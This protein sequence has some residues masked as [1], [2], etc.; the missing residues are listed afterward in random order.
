MTIVLDGSGLTLEKLVRIARHG[1][2]VELAPEALERIKVCRAM[3][4]DKLKAHEVMYGTNTGI[5]EFSEIILSDE[6]VLQFQRYLI[7]NHAA[8]IGDPAPIEHVRA[9]MAG[10]IN[11]HA[12]GNS[13]CRPEIT[14]TLIAMLNQGLTP[15]VWRWNEQAF[16]SPI[17]KRVTAWLPSTDRTCSPR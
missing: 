12:H 2:Q 7:Y 9:A 16:P 6:Q 13:G 3:L 4:E 8:G 11:V 1:E 14:L 17:C 10:R 5:G 15:V